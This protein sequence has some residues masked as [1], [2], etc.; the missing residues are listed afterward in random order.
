M[1]NRNLSWASSQDGDC[2]SV[3]YGPNATS[4]FTKTDC[5]KT[6]PFICEVNNTFVSFAFYFYWMEN[7]IGAQ[8]GDIWSGVA[9]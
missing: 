1:R 8:Q 3:N 5:N 7:I 6:M 9:G 4:T 2:V